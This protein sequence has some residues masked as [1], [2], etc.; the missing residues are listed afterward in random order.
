MD[1]RAGKR[2]GGMTRQRQKTVLGRLSH[3]QL[4]ELSCTMDA[5]LRDLPSESKFA[6]EPYPG[7]WSNFASEEDRKEA[8][9]GHRDEVIRFYQTHEE[10]SRGGGPLPWPAEKYDE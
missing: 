7:A 6:A 8:W 3:D 10:Y 1:Q 5:L 2:G 4:I 9:N